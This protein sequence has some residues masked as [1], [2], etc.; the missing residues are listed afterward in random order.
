MYFL[1]PSHNDLKQ[2]HFD[3]LSCL[4]NLTHL[5]IGDFVR[6]S[7]VFGIQDFERRHTILPYLNSLS[8]HVS[9]DKIPQNLSTVCQVGTAPKITSFN[10]TATDNGEIWMFYFA[11]KYSQVF[12]MTLSVWSDNKTCISKK[13]SLMDGK[14]QISRV[15]DTNCRNQLIRPDVCRI[16]R[17]DLLKSSLW[18]VKAPVKNIQY[19]AKKYIT[20]PTFEQRLNLLLDMSMATAETVKC[21]FEGKGVSLGLNDLTT[22]FSICPNLVSI[23]LKHCD[24]Y[25]AVDTLLYGCGSLKNLTLLTGGLYLASDPMKFTNEHKLKRVDTNSGT[26]SVDALDYLSTQCPLLG[27]LVLSTVQVLY[28]QD[29]TVWELADH[30]DGWYPETKQVTSEQKEAIE[31]I[32]T[33]FK[34]FET[35][36][37][38]GQMRISGSLDETSPY[39]KHSLF[40]GYLELK[41]GDVSNYKII[42]GD[43]DD[44]EYKDREGSED[45]KNMYD[46]LDDLP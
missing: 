19:T 11:A 14:V 46:A 30:Q 15:S 26:I 4:P 39:W 37:L 21:H 41:F 10:C 17:V 20:Q 7:M 12:D 3:I 42:W 40:R 38:L 25:L 16:I 2:F 23:D 33:Y 9:L 45:L 43:E 27:H 44:K 32:E 6:K 8:T 28:I 29:L 18:K 13:D 24:V 22:V 31:Y 36:R 5:T 35:K 1:E 34:D